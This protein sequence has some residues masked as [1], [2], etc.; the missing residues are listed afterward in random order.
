MMGTE[1]EA[2]APTL[3]TTSM[4]SAPIS[5]TVSV[6]DGNLAD[7]P[8]ELVPQSVS[9]AQSE[10]LK[11]DIKEKDPRCTMEVPSLKELNSTLLDRVEEELTREEFTTLNKT[12][13]FNAAKDYLKSLKKITRREFVAQLVD[14]TEDLELMREEKQSDSEFAQFF[15]VVVYGEMST[16][17]EFIYLDD[18]HLDGF[19]DRAKEGIKVADLYSTLYS[20]MCDAN[21]LRAKSIAKEDVRPDF[22][23]ELH[24]GS[25]HRLIDEDSDEPINFCTGPCQICGPIVATRGQGK[26]KADAHA[27]LAIVK[28]FLSSF[29][30]QKSL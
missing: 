7:H 12:K 4:T 26:G 10:Q 9:S 18:V 14:W 23:P 17:D 19:V 24:V 29:F 2:G 30:Q 8:W 27:A 6:L 22:D 21:V 20:A 16:M 3:M 25:A 13:V 28:P 15:M 11:K 1:T 5:S